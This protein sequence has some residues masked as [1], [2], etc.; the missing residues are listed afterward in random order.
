MVYT[1]KNTKLTLTALDKPDLLLHV[2]FENSL[3]KMKTL[4]LA[5]EHLFQQTL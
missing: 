5:T 1:I 4:S 2:S 3:K